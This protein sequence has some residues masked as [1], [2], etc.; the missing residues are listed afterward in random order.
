MHCRVEGLSP[1]CCL[2]RWRVRCL[3]SHIASTTI[4][5]AASPGGQGGQAPCVHQGVDRTKKERSSLSSFW[6]DVPEVVIQ[7]ASVLV[8]RRPHNLGTCT[9]YLLL[10]EPSFRPCPGVILDARFSFV[11]RCCDQARCSAWQGLGYGIQ[12]VDCCSAVISALPCL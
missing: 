5:C 3:S 9:F 1:V 6:Y 11:S 2:E 10:P 7:T 8:R 12:P 4:V